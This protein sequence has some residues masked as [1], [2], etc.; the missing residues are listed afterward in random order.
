MLCKYINTLNADSFGK[1]KDIFALSTI[2]YQ[3]DG[4]E[5]INPALWKTRNLILLSGHQKLTHCGPVT[6]YGDIDQGP[7]L[8][9]NFHVKIHVS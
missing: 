3:R 9:R 6:P 1:H 7:G 5:S 2:S 8:L 4:R